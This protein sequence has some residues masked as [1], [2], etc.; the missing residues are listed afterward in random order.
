MTLNANSILIGLLAGLASALLLV[1]AGTP[2]FLTIFLFASAALPIFIAGLGWSNQAAI[3]AV[4]TSFAI[5]MFTATPEAAM[6]SAVTTLLPSAWLSHLSTL[7]RP[8]S[9]LGGPEDQLVWYPLPQLMLHSATFM[10][11]A[12]LII[13]WM[14][15]YN[16][17]IVDQIVDN[18][19]L[20]LNQSGEGAQANFVLANPEGT[21]AALA[22][23]IP[24]MQSAMWLVILFSAWYFATHIVRLSGRSKRPRDNVHLTLRMPQLA[25][26]FLG[27][28]LV[29]MFF[30]GTI[31][32]IGAAIAGAFASGFM[33]AGLAV[34]HMKAAGKMWR[35]AAIWGSY[36]AILLFSF[37]AAVFAVIGLFETGKPT[38]LLVSDNKT[39]PAQ[40]NLNT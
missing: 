20:A 8:A 12:T 31:S 25:L 2:S 32:Y 30:D 29:L 34:L 22:K 35:N 10:V 5:L 37:P 33:M 16:A 14:I 38:P 19:I 18:L 11:I 39:D 24:F 3:A 28:G 13:G 21:K 27:V 40:D 4:I 9:E 6:T 17:D 26:V 15:G 23:L 1:G 7:A 36:L